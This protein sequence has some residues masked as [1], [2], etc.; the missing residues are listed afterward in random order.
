M[1]I[2]GR[3]NTQGF[4]HTYKSVERIWYLLN[5][6]ITSPETP[7]FN[8]GVLKKKNL[9][10]KKVYDI[11]KEKTKTLEEGHLRFGI[12]SLIKNQ[13]FILDELRLTKSIFL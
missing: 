5:G 8:S 13:R 11:M 6:T 4:L 7:D 3:M 12:M 1:Y 10:T 2:L 9:H